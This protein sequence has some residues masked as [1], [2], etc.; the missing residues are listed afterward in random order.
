MGLTVTLKNDTKYNVKLQVD[1]FNTDVIMLSVVMQSVILSIIVIMLNVIMLCNA[2]IS[3]VYHYAKW[4]Y[5]KCRYT[6]CHGA[7]ETTCKNNY[8]INKDSSKWNRIW[9]VNISLVI[10]G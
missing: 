10:L 4:R 5:A 3:I 2:Y 7:N 9:K 1:F 6:K 8:F